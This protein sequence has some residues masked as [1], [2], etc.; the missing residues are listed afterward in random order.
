MIWEEPRSKPPEGKQWF[1]V[2]VEFVREAIFEVAAES[3]EEARKMV[4]EKVIIGCADIHV[5]IPKGFVAWCSSLLSEIKIGEI[6]LAEER[7]PM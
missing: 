1:S 2:P 6:M 4:E 3:A 7:D 5:D